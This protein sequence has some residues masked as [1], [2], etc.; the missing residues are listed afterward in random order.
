MHTIYITLAPLVKGMAKVSP[1]ILSADFSNLGTE[2]KKVESFSDMLHVD[3]MDGHFAPNI[4]I[5]IPII[6][7]V[8]KATNLPLDIHLMIENPENLVEAFAQ[9]GSDIITVHAEVIKGPEIFDKIRSLG[10]KAGVSIN[11]DTPIEKITPYLDKV[12]MVLIMSVFPGFSG[13]EFID[14]TEKIKNL[15]QHYK[16]DIEVDGGINLETGKKVVEA[17]ADILVAG[18]FI[19]KSEDPGKTAQDLKNL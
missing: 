14:V 16:G 7:S 19:F 2:I 5:G 18:S 17:G 4:T 6:K 8:K 15:R 10:K 11:P 9:A 3:V 12:D 1:S 13:Q